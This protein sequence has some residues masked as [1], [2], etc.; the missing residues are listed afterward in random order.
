MKYLPILMIENLCQ[1][2]LDE[3]FTLRNDMLI[4]FIPRIKI[5]KEDFCKENILMKENSLI[6]V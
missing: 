4:I 2:F 3:I 1:I 5:D 6:N